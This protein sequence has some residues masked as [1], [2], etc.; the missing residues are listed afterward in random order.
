MKYLVP[1]IW[2]A[3]VRH[4][5]GEYIYHVYGVVFVTL[6]LVVFGGIVSGQWSCSL[7]HLSTSAISPKSSSL[8]AMLPGPHHL[9]P[10]RKTR[11][12]R[13]YAE[14][15]VTQQFFEGSGS[16]HHIFRKKNLICFWH[17]ISGLHRFSFDQRGGRKL[18]TNLY[19]GKYWNIP[20][21]LIMIIYIIIMQMSVCLCVCLK[22]FVG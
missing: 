2:T 17:Q 15:H 21:W 12:S 11:W 8:V 22:H 1:F 19:R 9:V 16:Q 6:Y 3:N 20:H 10:K 5:F 14:I 4:T 13:R 18:S 7:Q